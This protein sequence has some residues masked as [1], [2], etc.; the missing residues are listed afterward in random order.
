MANI[1]SFCLTKDLGEEPGLHISSNQQQ[2]EAHPDLGWNLVLE[3]NTSTKKV[4]F[5]DSDKSKR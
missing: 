3:A 5:Q 1:I 4:H 2:N